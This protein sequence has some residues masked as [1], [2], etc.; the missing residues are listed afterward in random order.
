MSLIILS[1]ELRCEVDTPGAEVLHLIRRS[2]GR[3][4]LWSGDPAY[5]NRRSPILFPFVGAVRDKQYRYEG[6]TYTIGQHGFAR[7]MEFGLKELEADEVWFHLEE[8][9][10]TLAKYPFPFR[11][12]AGY[13]TGANVLYVKW[14]VI[15]PSEDKDLY[16]SIGAHPAFAIPQLAGHALRLYDQ[17]GKPIEQFENRIFGTGGC[18]T[19]RT[20]IMK[21]P[22]G[23]LP[24]SESLF[25]ND[26]LVLENRQVSKIDLLEP[27]PGSTDGSLRP[28]LTVEFDAP[29]VGIWSPPHKNAPFVCIEPWNGRCDAE[30]FTG[31]L[32]DRP[33][34]IRLAPGKE[35]FD[36]YMITVHEPTDFEPEMVTR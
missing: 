33:Y 31:E 12:Q 29:V 18:V 17:E 26:A 32:Q 15:N 5:W 35:F 4:I 27:I 11:L 36:R 13:L 21:T 30:D 20:E 22:D 8:T 14:I 19:N 25:D 3:E 24:L 16:F 7:D 6:K 23:Y 28:L 9:E 1:D 10:E 2:D 34:E